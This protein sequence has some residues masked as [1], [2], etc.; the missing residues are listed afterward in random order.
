MADNIFDLTDD[1]FDD[2]IKSGKWVIDFWATWCNPCRMQGRLLEAGAAELAAAG[3]NIGKVNVDEASKLAM[4]FGVQSIP[5][6]LLYKDGQQV[7][8]FVGVQQVSKL[9]EEL[10]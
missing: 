7:Q 9:L 10:K 4:R 8:E 3:I 2:K 1:N 6:L 5:T